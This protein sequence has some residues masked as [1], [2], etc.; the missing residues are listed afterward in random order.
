MTCASCAEHVQ[1]ILNSLPGVA[2][3]VSYPAGTAHMSAPSGVEDAA[4]VAAVREAG[5]D[6]RLAPGG[7]RLPAPGEAAGLHVAVI[8][9]G[10]AAFAGAI[11]AQDA[12]ARVTLIERGTL[13][14]TCVNVGCV[15]S[16]M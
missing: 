16:K 9:G 12:G 6:A 5:Y 4:L 1:R 13:G 14:G 10:S 8:G 3:T 15:P 11:R 2:A 7:H